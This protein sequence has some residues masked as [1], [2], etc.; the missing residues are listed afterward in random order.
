MDAE[1]S[2]LSSSVPVRRA[3]AR[4]LGLAIVTRAALLAVAL[5]A[6]ALGVGI[7]RDRQHAQRWGLI[8]EANSARLLFVERDDAAAR[9][10]LRPG[11]ALTAIDLAPPGPVPGTLDGTL[12]VSVR[13]G[14]GLGMTVLTGPSHGLG[15]DQDALLAAAAAL[16]LAG[17]L[18]G[19]LAPPRAAAR[20]F[21]LFAPLGALAL[22]C[23]LAQDP[24]IGWAQWLVAPVA[25]AAMAAYVFLQ[26]AQVGRP[27]GRWSSAWIDVTLCAQAALAV[28]ALLLAPHLASAQGQPY[29]AAIVG[30]EFLALLALPHLLAV[31]RLGREAAAP[32]RRRVRLALLVGCIGWL[33]ALALGWAPAMAT[34]LGT[35]Y[36]VPISPYAGAISL[37]LLAITYPAIAVRG[38]LYWLEVALRRALVT[39]VTGGA[40]LALGGAIWW[41][42]SVTLQLSIGGQLA[43]GAILALLALPA[44]EPT[45]RALQGGIDRR[46]DLGQF[47]YGPALQAVADALL[48]APGQSTFDMETIAGVLVREAAPLLGVS[49]ISVWLRARDQ[50]RWLLCDAETPRGRE[51]AIPSLLL[52]TAAQPFMASAATTLSEDPDALPNRYDGRAAPGAALLCVPVYLA[53]DL[54]AMLL[55]GPR[56]SQDPYRRPDRAA[57]VLLA[58]QTAA[59]LQL[60]DLLAD[61]Q[62]RNAELAQLTGRLARA[63]EEERRHLSRE[64]H[65]AV[66]QDLVSITRQLRRHQQGALPEAIWNDLIAQAQEAL[67][68]TRRICN[69]LRPAILD[70]G[71]TSAIRELIERGYAGEQPLR[72]QLE[73]CGPEQRLSEDCE[74][75]L[76][77][78]TQESL[79]N[80]VKHARA[81]FATVTV[82]FEA[83]SAQVCVQDDGRGFVVPARLEEIAGDHLGLIGMRE[84]LAELGGGLSVTSQPGKGTVVCGHVSCS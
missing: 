32:A 53:A 15:W 27:Y 20:L 23:A 29:L 67:T 45:R 47:D 33:P 61:L 80:V 13:Y 59:A 78:V 82:R 79:A 72:V 52:T 73:V 16:W 44:F 84:R 26:R 8:Y 7:V 56:R 43:L 77:R 65:D 4:D 9:G 19:A 68:T 39:C 25:G 40:L 76:Y 2:L 64:L 30:F 17:A 81:R 60:A 62:V 50:H 37:G 74:F 51:R 83:A 6:L 21:A 63:R 14:A 58:R 11:D 18:V 24:V 55:I 34:L 22:C 38:D 31:A 57:L 71:L 35:G 12:P 10:G 66:A 69:D 70:L 36:V 54:R 5:V 46:F 41:A 75:A 3:P 48:P 49:R 42:V 28:V 1:L